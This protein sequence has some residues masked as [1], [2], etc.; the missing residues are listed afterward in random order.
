MICRLCGRER[1]TSGAY[2]GPL[3]CAW[4]ESAECESVRVAYRRGQIDALQSVSLHDDATGD[5]VMAEIEKL[6]GGK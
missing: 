3:V 4:T 5:S 2:E 6:G 1:G